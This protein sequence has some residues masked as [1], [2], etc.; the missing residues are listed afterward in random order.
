MERGEKGRKGEVKEGGRKLGES[1]ETLQLLTL[2]LAGS[3]E[4]HGRWVFI[5]SYT[6]SD[7]SGGKA[8]PLGLVQGPH[9][10]ALKIFN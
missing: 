2:V 3:G 4:G 5:G 6:D 7:T 8:Q 10:A 1:R 9:S